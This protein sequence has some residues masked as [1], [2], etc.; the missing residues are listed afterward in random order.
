MIRPSHRANF[1]PEQRLESCYGP[2]VGWHIHIATGT[3]NFDLRSSFIYEWKWARYCIR[4]RSP[5]TNFWI[6][7][8]SSRSS[9]TSSWITFINDSTMPLMSLVAHDA[10]TMQDPCTDMFHLQNKLSLAAVCLVRPVS[11]WRSPD[12]LLWSIE[13]QNELMTTV[14]PPS[15]PNSTIWPDLQWIL[16]F[17]S[18][19]YRGSGWIAI[20][21]TKSVMGVRL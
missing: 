19:K 10:D 7:L 20:T 21:L 18:A 16:S 14:H 17:A 6:H 3:S 13:S 9:S 1:S 5:R 8:P 12:F 2:H 4:P 11:Y 15:T